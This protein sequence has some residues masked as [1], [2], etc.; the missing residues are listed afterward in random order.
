MSEKN[1]SFNSLLENI[2]SV[3]RTIKINNI[4]VEVKQYLPV[5]EKLE[6]ITKV[7][8]EL[9]GNKYN[10]VNP[11]QLDVYT[12]VEIVRAYTNI[13][14]PKDKEIWELY[15]IMEIEQISNKVIAAIPAVEYDFIQDGVEKSISAYYGYQTSVL[16]IL[17]A[18]SQDYSNLK[19]DAEEIRNNIAEPNNLTLLK[20]VMTKLG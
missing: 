14:F 6:L 5:N 20:D 13:E 10:F 12:T 11:V 9:A 19:L 3:A 4:D 2:T 17:E 18:V 1:V 15:D 16:G 8:S 7:V